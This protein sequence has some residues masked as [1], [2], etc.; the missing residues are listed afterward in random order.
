MV[1]GLR[2]MVGF[3]WGAVL[4]TA[5]AASEVPRDAS[6]PLDIVW[7]TPNPSMLE[8]RDLSSFVQPTASGRLESALWGCTRNE[9][10]RFHAGLD[11]KPLQR[12]R[13]GEATDP[14][15]AV[16]D[17]EIVYI[18]RVAGHSS[19]GR[20][21]VIEHTGLHFPV[22]TLYAHLARVVDGLEPGQ[23]VKAG[24]QIAVMGRSA[25]G[26]VI[27]RHRAHLH[28]EIGVRLSTDFQSWF[29]RQ[30]FGSPNHHGH[31]NGMNLVA[32]DPLQFYRDLQEGTIDGPEGF[33]G[34]EPTAVSL[35]V[36]T[37]E[38]PD[39][40]RRYPTLIAGGL[41]NGN[42]AGWDVDFTWYGLPK[43]WLPVYEEDGITG[44]PGTLQLLD[45]DRNLIES[46]RCR[47]MLRIGAG[48]NVSLGR[49]LRK[50]L[51][52]LFEIF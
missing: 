35:R 19:Y 8:G 26:Y 24:E 34:N 46:N 25:G 7:P 10:T 11:L 50:H 16:M 44:E 18:N 33:V 45:M 38:I 40:V 42:L 39:Y 2:Q 32:F 13:R 15:F 12:D 4:L 1:R 17:G 51:E 5:L 20:Y 36:F 27:P 41:R 43:R 49:D 3:L 48:G 6:I 14:I 52:L 30:G 28:F 21:L 47:E 31:Y 23:S 29:D 22:Y 37:S 9:G